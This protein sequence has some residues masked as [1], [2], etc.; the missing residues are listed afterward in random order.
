MFNEFTSRNATLLKLIE[1]DYYK[2]SFSS[3]YVPDIEI[4]EDGR[5][6]IKSSKPI[7]ENNVSSIV[8]FILIN[9]DGKITPDS[10]SQFI[11]LLNGGYLV[12]LVVNRPIIKENIQLSYVVDINN[13]PLSKIGSTVNDQIIYQYGFDSIPLYY[14]SEQIAAET[15]KLLSNNE[16]VFKK[17]I[18]PIL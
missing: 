9:I 18:M 8:K 11:E 4:M 10:S 7:V 16:E 14:G 15:V 3:Y 1:N 13:I 5:I 17:F 2:N 6:F 12:R